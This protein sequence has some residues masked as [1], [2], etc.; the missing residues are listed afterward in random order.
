MIAYYRQRINRF[1]NERFETITHI[2]RIK[3]SAEEKH[4]EQWELQKSKENVAELQKALS[5]ARTKLYEERQITLKFKAENESLQMR[6][7]EDHKRISELVGIV[8]PVQQN[9]V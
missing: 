6:T 3:L 4:R 8:E 2:E 5:D 1:E 7:N 9:I